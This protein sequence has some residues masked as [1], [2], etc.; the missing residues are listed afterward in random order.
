MT[1]LT[2]PRI[3]QTGTNEWADVESNDVAIREVIN[4]ELDNENLKAN[5]GITAEKLAASAKPVTWY[6]PTVIPTEESRSFTG[7][8]TLA[9]ADEIKEVVVPSNGLIALGYRAKVKSSV[10][11]A[12]AAAVF[13]GANQIKSLIGGETGAGASGT[14]FVQFATSSN[15]LESYAESSTPDTTTT[16]QVVTVGLTYISVAAGTYNVNVKFKAASGSVT[17]K[18]RRM[19]VLVL[20]N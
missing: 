1:K 11:G 12:A 18:E 19:W 8:G 10:A 13:L 17:A 5:A 16:G 2:L 9:T 6:P 15:G 3:N 4:G 20:G 7:Y 14:N